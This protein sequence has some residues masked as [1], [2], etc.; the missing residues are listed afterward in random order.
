MIYWVW[1]NS[2][3]GIGPVTER[4]LLEKYKCPEEVYRAKLEDLICCD[5]VSEQRAHIIYENKSLEEANKIL[6][7]AERFGISIVNINDASFPNRLRNAKD[8]PVLLYYKGT[9]FEPDKTV[10]IVGPR[11]CTQTTKQKTIDIALECI[12]E[13]KIIVSGLARGVDGYSH[14][15]AIKNNAKTIAVV[16]CGLDLCFPKEH[17]MLFELI[18]KDG[19]ILSEYAPGTPARK[20]NFPRRNKL[21]A[22][23]SDDLYVIDAGRNSGALIT[24]K[25]WEKMAEKNREAIN[26]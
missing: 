24:Q 21:I 19:V 13:D 1:L 20:Y 26:L 2:L 11:R 17:E 4:A 10:G 15:V 7:D 12:K 14:T 8:L 9:L 16:G 5:G 6:R 18:Q 23:L 22:A 3:R 25:E